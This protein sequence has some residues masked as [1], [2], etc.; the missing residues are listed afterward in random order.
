MFSAAIGKFVREVFILYFFY[1]VVSVSCERVKL[2]SEQITLLL[3]ASVTNVFWRG[4]NERM[5]TWSCLSSVVRC[6]LS[7]ACLLL[8]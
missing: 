2:Q 1:D 4:L 5:C 6:C 3:S 8:L 7:A